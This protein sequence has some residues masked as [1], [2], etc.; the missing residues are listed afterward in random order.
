[1]LKSLEYRARPRPAAIGAPAPHPVTCIIKI[2]IGMSDTDDLRPTTFAFL[3]QSLRMQTELQLGLLY[4]GEEK[5][6]PEPDFAGARH[7]IDLLT[8][9]QE[10]TKGNLTLEEQR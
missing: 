10:K 5:D 9:L 1:M 8:M 4:F 2:V 6:R 7:T 3:T